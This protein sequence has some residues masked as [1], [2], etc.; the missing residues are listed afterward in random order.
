M[1]AIKILFKDVVVSLPSALIHRHPN[2]FKNAGNPAKLSKTRIHGICHI[3]HKAVDVRSQ[4]VQLQN[5]EINWSLSM[6]R[7]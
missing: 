6:V 1:K 2:T 3:S 4:K 7:K 5:D